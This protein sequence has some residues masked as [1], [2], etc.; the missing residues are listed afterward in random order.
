MHSQAIS[1]HFIDSMNFLYVLNL[2]FNNNNCKFAAQNFPE[3][4]TILN[5]CGTLEI[6][7]LSFQTAN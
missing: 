7:K 2:N 6:A 5:V 4:Q 3:I 1:I